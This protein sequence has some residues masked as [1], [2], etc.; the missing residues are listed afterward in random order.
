MKSIVQICEDIVHVDPLPSAGPTLKRRNR[1]K[2]HNSTIHPLPTK[3]MTE[4]YASTKAYP[5]WWSELE[6]SNVLRKRRSSEETVLERNLCF[7]D[8]PGFDS[9]TSVLEG[10]ENVLQYIEDQIHKSSALENMSDAELL[11]ILGGGG[12]NQVDVVLYMS[13][14]GTIYLYE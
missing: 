12:G 6:E 8:S 11:S 9:G 14:H 10:M 4:I 3:H 1:S 7:V 5:R 13:T 2:S